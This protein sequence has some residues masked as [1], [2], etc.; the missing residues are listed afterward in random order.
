MLT[1]LR[2]L[3]TLPRRH[4]DLLREYS[5]LWRAVQAGWIGE[6]RRTED[7]ARAQR[8]KPRSWA[9]PQPPAPRRPRAE[10]DTTQ[11]AESGFFNA[12]R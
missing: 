3:L 11:P 1:R 2:D 7:E 9:D 12:R 8:H 6:R 10:A 5:R 4:Q